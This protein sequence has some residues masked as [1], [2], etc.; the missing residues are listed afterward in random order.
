[1]TPKRAS[2]SLRV[3]DR[4]VVVAVTVVHVMQVSLHQ[5]VDVSSVRHPFVPT[6]FAVPVRRS[7]LAARL[8]ARA[9]RGVLSSTRELVLVDVT[10]V[11]VMQVTVVQ[12]VDVSFVT[13]GHVATPGSVLVLMSFVRVARLVRHGAN[14]A[15]RA[16][17]TIRRPIRRAKVVFPAR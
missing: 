3:R 15:R 17:T 1:M 8:A 7:V 2:A 14:L 10:F 5:V 6:T 13:E 4:T 16:K 12:V 11:D 9:R